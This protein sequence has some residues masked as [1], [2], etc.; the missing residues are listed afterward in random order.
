V[1]D[2]GDELRRERVRQ[3]LSVDDISVRTRISLRSLDAIETNDFNRLPGVVFARNFVRLYAQELS[4]DAD[5]LVARLPKVDIEAAPLP[6]PPAGSRR[7]I[8]DPRIVAA[9]TSVLWIA[10]AAGAVTGA[11]Y[12]YNH[13]GR[14]SIVAAAPPPKALPQK[15]QPAPKTIEARAADSPASTLDYTSGPVISQAAA[16]DS[17]NSDRPVQVVLTAREATWVQVTVDGQTAF[18]ALLHPHDKRAVSADAQVKVV[19]G[20]AGGLDISLNGKVLDA[21]GPHGQVRTVRLT[22]EG[23]QFAPQNPPASAPL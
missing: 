12:Y 11:W 3:G 6:I 16:T 9:I 23:P 5:A 7:R 18:A 22:A 10:T 14:R 8:W 21:I 2:I 13:Y 17:E 15:A 20:N 19:T 1:S 4:L